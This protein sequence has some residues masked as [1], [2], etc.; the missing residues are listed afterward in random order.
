MN[1]NKLFNTYR[2][3]SAFFF[4]NNYINQSV[5]CFTNIGAHY[6]SSHN[7]YKVWAYVLVLSTDQIHVLIR[8][9]VFNLKDGML[10]YLFSKAKLSEYKSKRNQK[11]FSDETKSTKYQLHCLSV[12][13][14]RETNKCRQDCMACEILVSWTSIVF[15]AKREQ[16][17]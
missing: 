9:Q 2:M 16:N 7:M 3:N 1:S 13:L 15:P 6:F 10:R 8:K 17:K 4:D 14:G 5:I 11:L 12:V